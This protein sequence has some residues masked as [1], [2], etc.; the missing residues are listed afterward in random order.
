MFMLNRIFE[1]ESQYSIH[2]NQ[3]ARAPVVNQRIFALLLVYITN[4]W[5]LDI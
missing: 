4:E 1:S 5:Y 3:S 2:H